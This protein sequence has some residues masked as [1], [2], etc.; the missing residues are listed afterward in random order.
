MQTDRDAAA[1]TAATIQAARDLGDPFRDLTVEAIE[2]RMQQNLVNK[3]YDSLHEAINTGVGDV[4]IL[5]ASYHNN[6]AVLEEMGRAASA[7]AVALGGVAATD[8]SGK[9]NTV[10][11]TNPDGTPIYSTNP[12]ADSGAVENQ[13]QSLRDSV[14]ASGGNMSP[15]QL[16]T[17]YSYG[18]GV[19]YGPGANTWDPENF[20]AYK[21]ILAFANQ[22]STGNEYLSQIKTLETQRYNPMNGNEYNPSY[23]YGSGAETFIGTAQRLYGAYQQS[24]APVININVSPDFSESAQSIAEKT[25][26]A[27]SRELARQATNT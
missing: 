1:A 22:D 4:E 5:S 25:A 27:I 21:A 20:A 8:K 15:E 10:I 23:S 18:K 6:V 2:M 16:A 14:A 3:S 13:A 11:G 9:A 7:A 17:F 19:N 12:Y 24:T 26:E